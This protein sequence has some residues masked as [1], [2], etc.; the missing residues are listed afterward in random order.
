MTK[1][2]E[3]WARYPHRVAKR[4]AEKAFKAALKRADA[5][6]IIEGVEMYKQTKPQWCNWAHPASWLNADRWDDQPA[7]AS[8]PKPT[9]TPSTIA[10]KVLQAMQEADS[11]QG[12]QGQLGFT[13]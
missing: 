3:F 11:R 7:S 12:Q 13:L 8:I 9:T 6:T 1:F 4:A 5:E 10:A 2:E